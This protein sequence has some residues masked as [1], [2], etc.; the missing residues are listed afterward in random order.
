MGWGGV[1]IAT[2]GGRIAHRRSSTDRLYAL[3][4]SDWSDFCM[5][6]SFLH[7]FALVARIGMF[8]AILH[9]RVVPI[10][11]VVRACC[12]VSGWVLGPFV[13]PELGFPALSVLLGTDGAF[14]FGVLVRW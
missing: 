11:F 12:L 7:S 4:P 10:W 8:P 9:I 5:D 3:A 1:F 6:C 14:L 2:V 13:V